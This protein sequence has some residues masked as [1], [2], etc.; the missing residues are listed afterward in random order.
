MWG[1]EGRRRRW[2]ETHAGVGRG[3]GSLVVVGVVLLLLA[4]VLIASLGKLRSGLRQQ[5]PGSV[6]PPPTQPLR[7]P[8][9]GAPEG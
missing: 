1:G 8:A 6:A 5:S 2:A 4:A 7:A 3:R 9:R